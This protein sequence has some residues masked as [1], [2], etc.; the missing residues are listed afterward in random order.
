MALEKAGRPNQE[1]ERWCTVGGHTFRY[2]VTG[3]GPPVILLH[4]LLGFSFSWRR[5]LKALGE[6]GTLYV[7]DALGAGYSDH[8]C[9]MDCG[10][11]AQAER[12]LGLMD[13]L[14]IDSAPVAG[15][16][17]GGAVAMMMA[18]LSSERGR[19]RVSRLLLAD[20]VHPWAEYELMQRLLIDF[21]LALGF[22]GPLLLR[23]KIL[24][25][26]FLRRLYGDP[27]RI[28]DAT[29][30]GYT[31]ALNQARTLEYGMGVVK[32]WRNDL[33]RLEAVAPHLAD[34][35]AMLFWGTEDHAVKIE[36]AAR[37]A[38][39][40]KQCEFIPLPGIGH[41]PME[42]APQLFNPPAKRFLLSACP[43]G[44]C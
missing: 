29:I 44:H 11:A 30:E 32:D 26:I 33:K 28:T 9:P 10:L 38:R 39:V 42:E 34:V 21:P 36:S 5:N 23:S 15:N 37:L 25:I 43:G 17:H 12:I 40:F 20:P 8:P 31:A 35:P 24:Q 13:A 4:G 1:L 16:S 14:G 2:L 3:S 41:M 6:C 7:V 22:F 18:G 19:P 27:R